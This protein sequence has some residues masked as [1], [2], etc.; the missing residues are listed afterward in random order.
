MESFHSTGSEAVDIFFTIRCTWFIGRITS[1][2]ASAELL[3]PFPFCATVSAGLVD[4]RPI[5]TWRTRLLFEDSYKCI[6]TI[7]F[8]FLFKLI[9]GWSGSAAGQSASGKKF[10]FREGKNDKQPNFFFSRLDWGSGDSSNE[11]LHQFNKLFAA[12][13]AGWV[14]VQNWMQWEGGGQKK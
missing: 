3:F 13:V 14:K 9:W 7:Y 8:L 12:G 10:K 6:Y 1:W 5:K 2:S 11:R 4:G